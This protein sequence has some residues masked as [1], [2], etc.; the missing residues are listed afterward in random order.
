MKQSIILLLFIFL[1]VAELS[2]QNQKL[3]ASD[4][5][6][7]DKFGWSIDLDENYLIVGAPTKADFGGN[8]G[9]AYIF[10]F[11]GSEW[12]EEAKLTASDTLAYNEFGYSVSIDGDFA[13]V[14]ARV[15][16]TG[17]GAVYIFKRNG[18]VWEEEIK[19]NCPDCGTQGQAL[20]GRAVSLKGDRVLIGAQQSTQSLYEAGT[21]YIFKREN[22]NWILEETFIPADA[23]ITAQFGWSVSLTDNYAMIGAYSDPLTFNNPMGAAYIYKLDGNDWLFDA[24][25]LPDTLAAYQLF[26]FSV[27]IDGNYAVAGAPGG[28]SNYGKRA[29]V[30]EN[31]AGQWNRKTI[32]LPYDYNVNFGRSVSILGN[33]IIVGNTRY[34]AYLFRNTQP[35]WN[36]FAKIEPDD[37]TYTVNDFGESVS[38]SENFVAV[39]DPSGIN[40]SS[41]KT[42]SVHLFDKNLLVNVDENQLAQPEDFA[43]YQNYPN[44]FNPSTSIQYAISNR[45]FV[46][47]K[48]Y[49]VLGNEIATLVNEEK[50]RG[51]YSVNFDASHLASGIYLYRLSVV[52]MAQRDLVLK[53]GQAGSFTET[54]KMILLR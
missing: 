39:G 7:F 42:G 53:D 41:L 4:A 6:E 23:A 11:N 37:T 12:V 45:Q 48:V 19:I 22:N 18:A 30:F 40:N 1:T 25:L 35:D 3:I 31:E 16:Y 17:V 8:S 33:D 46:S 14:G 54:K 52:P 21:A 10:R 2:G 29:I 36:L 26:G 49:D 32:L 47:L 13:A 51:V 28:G 50:D 44:P 27:S 38:L 15:N 5:E 34:G 9:A 43:L 20:F 24:K